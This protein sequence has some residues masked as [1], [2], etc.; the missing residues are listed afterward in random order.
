MGG[1]AYVLCFIYLI[2]LRWMAKPILYLSLVAI[3]VLLVG[4]GFYVFFLGIKYNSE[5]HTREVMIGMAIM[6]WI[7]A[8]LYLCIVFCC[9]KTIK[10]AAAIMQAASDFVRSTP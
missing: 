3:F 1:I 9:W 6:I 7:M 8:A 4:G 10:L 2:L 5:D